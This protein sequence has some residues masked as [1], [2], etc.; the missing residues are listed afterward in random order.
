MQ[1]GIQR[2]YWLECRV[3][4]ML[5]KSE[6]QVEDLSFVRTYIDAVGSW[7]E[8]TLKNFL[9]ENVVLQITGDGPIQL[10]EQLT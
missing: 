4:A 8:F 2:G 6:E 7:Q 9:G 1:R 3:A 10:N 5:R